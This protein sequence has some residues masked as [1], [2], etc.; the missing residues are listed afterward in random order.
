M[1]RYKGKVYAWDVA[2][3]IFDENGGF[4]ASPWNRK[5]K[6]ITM[7]DMAKIAFQAA[8]KAVSDRPFGV[9]TGLAAWTL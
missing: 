4:R 9:T 3:E 6:G 8:R 7:D 1:S 5:D 2:N